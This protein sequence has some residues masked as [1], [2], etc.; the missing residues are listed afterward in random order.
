[1]KNTNQRVQKKNNSIRLSVMLDK[2]NTSNL[3]SIQAKLIQS[4]RKNISFS[5]V[6]NQVVKIGIKQFK[7]WE[8][9]SH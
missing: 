7:K 5:F 4:T 6:I 9:G 3:R 2:A 8:A 1:M